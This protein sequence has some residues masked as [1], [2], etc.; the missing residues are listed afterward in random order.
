[1][2]E[3]EVIRH[4]R[5]HLETQFPKACAHC[6]R[7]YTDLHDFVSHTKQLG[8]VMPYDAEMGEWEPDNPIGTML[9][10]NCE[11]RNTLVLTSKGM[12]L[13][14]LWQLLYWVR[15]ETLKRQTTPTAL[16]TELREKMHRKLLAAHDPVNETAAAPT[17]NLVVPEPL[18]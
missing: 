9:F 14:L 13:P 16:F 3:G 15:I 1:M 8:H 5:E 11:C 18:P 4:W 6:H 10:A 12:P 7:S 17:T 2:T